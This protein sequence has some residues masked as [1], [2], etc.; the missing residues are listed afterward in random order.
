M[1]AAIRVSLQ[2]LLQPIHR[3]GREHLLHGAIH[4]IGS[5]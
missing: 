2:D 1:V 4:L 5:H 3:S